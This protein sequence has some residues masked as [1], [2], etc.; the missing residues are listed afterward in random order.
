MRDTDRDRTSHIVAR[1]DGPVRSAGDLRGRTLAVGASDSPQATLIPLGLVRAAG[2]EPA[3]RRRHRPAFDV[4]VGKHGDHVGG[5][6][7]RPARLK[8][9]EADAARDARPELGRV[10]HRTAPS[11]RRRSRSSPGRPRF[12]HCI[13]TVREGFRVMRSSAW[14]DALFAMRYDEPAHR[15]MMD[16][17][18]SEGVAAGPHHRVRCADGGGRG[19]ALLRRSAEHVTALPLFPV[20]T[21]GSWPRPPALARRAAAAPSRRAGSRRSSTA[22]PTPPCARRA[23]CRRTPAST[24]SPTA[25]CAATTSI[26][27]SRRSSTASG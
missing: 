11:T 8:R 9:G 21:V 4:L 6:L 2:L 25:S 17:E 12:D 3:S 16:L 10:A 22:S 5:E 13:F 7:R 14:L 20:T 1:A 26:R 15:E 23:R 18:G 19:R 24:S 27:S